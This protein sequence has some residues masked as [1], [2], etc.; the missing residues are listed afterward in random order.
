[1]QS[2]VRRLSQ[3][4]SKLQLSPLATD[5]LDTMLDVCPDSRSAIHAVAAHGWL[6]AEDPDAS[7]IAEQMLDRG[8]PVQYWGEERDSLTL[9]Y[10]QPKN[11]FGLI[12]SLN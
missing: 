5:L 2:W 7:D 12:Y 4:G 9:K 10:A 3:A 11:P 6:Q 1:M 8:P